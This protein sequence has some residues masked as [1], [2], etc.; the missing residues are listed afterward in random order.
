MATA[1]RITMV[2][3]TGGQG[4]GGMEKH[5]A[6][7]AH[8]L[9]RQGC[10]V[11]VIAHP[12]YAGQFPASIQFHPM[13]MQLGRKNPWLRFRL[14]RLLRRRAP[15]ICHAQGNKAAQL[16]ARCSPATALT[17]GTVHGIKSSH[18]DF[19]RLDGV[20]AVS[21]SIF[22]VLEHGNKTLI[23]NGIAPP[24]Q[25]SSGADTLP[26]GAAR[27]LAVAIG[28]LEPVK[29]FV[30]LLEAW[31]Q[32][33]TP[34]HLLII[35]EGSQRAQL[36]RRIS[37]LELGSG[38]TLAGHRDDIAACLSQADLCIISSEREG[39]SYVLIEALQAG[40]PVI[41]TP[42]GGPLELLPQDCLA[43]DTTAA[44]LSILIQRHLPH[45]AELCRQQGVLMTR[46]RS[47]FTLETMATK[48]LA[49]YQHLSSRTKQGI[50][51]SE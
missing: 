48:T 24:A 43:V 13:P 23:Y 51:P 40:C 15:D 8:E 47:E 6:E 19:T 34:G 25:A 20:I 49:F 21:Q 36:S 22:D 33:T 44:A 7:L 11:D 9:S 4:W 32:L 46:V 16:I 1:L 10:R 12:L 37:E 3:A 28:R 5:T 27:P 39:F 35:G 41:S 45:A 29:G 26:A 42:V 18:S 2:L 17:V 31:V 14:R 50:N 38:V 30:T